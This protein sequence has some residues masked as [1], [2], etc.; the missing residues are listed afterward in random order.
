MNF[1]NYHFVI[2]LAKTFLLTQARPQD[3]ANI[4][5]FKPQKDGFRPIVDDS[6]GKILRRYLI[7][8]NKFLP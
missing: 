6:I 5:V 4:P 7:F 1:I 2:L 3:N 8:T